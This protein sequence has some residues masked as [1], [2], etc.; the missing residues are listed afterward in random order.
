MSDSKEKELKVGRRSQ[1]GTIRLSTYLP[2]L[3]TLSVTY[4]SDR[5]ASVMLTREQVQ[6]L[7]Q[8]LTE[9]EAS[10]DSEEAAKEPWDGNE[11]REDAA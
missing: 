7:R 5:A 6:Q 1:D 3:L 10:M 8:M 9:L 4:K 11:R 2:H